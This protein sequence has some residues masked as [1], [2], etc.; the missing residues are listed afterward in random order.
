MTPYLAPLPLLEVVEAG[1]LLHSLLEQMAGLE[2]E[3]VLAQ[4][5]A[6]ATHLL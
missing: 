6:Q 2:E 5:V 3:V 1:L 4:M